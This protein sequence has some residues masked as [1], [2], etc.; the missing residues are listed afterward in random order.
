MAEITG[1][2]PP[3]RDLVRAAR[4]KAGLKNRDI[5]RGINS[6]DPRADF[7][8]DEV[9]SE[10]SRSALGEKR[11]QRMFDGIMEALQAHFRDEKTWQEVL[12]RHDEGVRGLRAAA[13]L[14]EEAVKTGWQ[15]PA[16]VFDILAAIVV[17]KLSADGLLR[18]RPLKGATTD[19]TAKALRDA[20]QEM[21]TQFFSDLVGDAVGDARDATL[22]PTSTKG[23][24]SRG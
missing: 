4:D 12:E 1:G 8:P 2:R 14:A 22:S 18:S 21:G 13:W 15:K 20:V 9:A 16:D 7:G 10:L 3:I 11:S 24:R 6:V 19:A 23:R 5:A 17:E